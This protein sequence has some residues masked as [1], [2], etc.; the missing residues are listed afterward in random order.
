[1]RANIWFIV[2]GGL[3]LLGWFMMRFRL[4]IFHLIN[5]NLNWGFGVL[6][7]EIEDPRGGLPYNPDL[8]EPTQDIATRHDSLVL[9]TA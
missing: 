5:S 9:W 4:F 8:Y 6:S 7:A 2:A 3:G 1:M